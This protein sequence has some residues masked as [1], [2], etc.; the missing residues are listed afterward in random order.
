MIPH[1][2]RREKQ[3][4]E[5][6]GGDHLVNVLAL[7]A[8]KGPVGQGTSFWHDAPLSRRE[9]ATLSVTGNVPVVNQR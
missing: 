8:L 2:Y 7:G 4:F 6:F 3:L 1:L 9:R 5:R